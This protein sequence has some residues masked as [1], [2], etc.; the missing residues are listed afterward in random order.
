MMRKKQNKEMFVYS[1][2]ITKTLESFSSVKDKRDEITKTNGKLWYIF[3]YEL[4][5][6]P[7]LTYKEKYDIL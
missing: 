2:Q 1:Y 3:G 4:K 5:S 7:W 6:K